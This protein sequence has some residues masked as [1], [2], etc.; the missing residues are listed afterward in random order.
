[1]SFSLTTEQR[2]VVENRGGALLVSAAA[3]NA[4]S[5]IF[6]EGR[7]MYLNCVNGYTLQFLKDLSIDLPPI[8][9]PRRALEG[10]LYQAVTFLDREHEHLLLSRAPHLKTTR[11]HPN[12]LDVIPATGGK[13]RGMDAILD[14]FGLTPGQAMAFGDGEND[15]SML[16]HAG[17]GVAMGTASQYV[18]SQADFS[19]ASVDEE[20]IPRA[21]RHFGLL[22]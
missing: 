16:L 13:D 8:G 12:F 6:L 18:K 15:L 21:L 4:F 20:G 9:D 11:W 22:D 2:A 3:G 17:I 7:D 14:H 19:T 1:M 10:E 5:C